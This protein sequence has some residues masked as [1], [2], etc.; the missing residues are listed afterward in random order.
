MPAPAA[1]SAHFS[2]GETK[3]VGM[4]ALDLVADDEDSNPNTAFSR[5]L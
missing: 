3:N 4:T 1:A 2:S 5:R